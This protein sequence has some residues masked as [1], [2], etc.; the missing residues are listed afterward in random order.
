MCCLHCG[1]KGVCENWYMWFLCC[2]MAMCIYVE[3]GNMTRAVEIFS[4]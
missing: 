1:R 3:A 4:M 2:C